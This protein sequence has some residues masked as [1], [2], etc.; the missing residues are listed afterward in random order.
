M[1]ELRV[2]HVLDFFE[3]YSLHD[4]PIDGLCFD[5]EMQSMK[6]MLDD[7]DREAQSVSLCLLFKK[8]SKYTFTYPMERFVFDMRAVYRAT[9]RKFEENKY[10]LHLLI[11]M[12]EIEEKHGRQHELIAGEMLIG[13]ADMEVIGGLSREAME[14]KWKEEE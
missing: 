8:V 5:F 7:C 14:Y 13:F 10:E 9:L 1:N 11:E 6:L 12:P 2:D 3:W 4:I